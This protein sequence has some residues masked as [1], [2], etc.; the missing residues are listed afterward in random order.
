L[1]LNKETKTEPLTNKEKKQK[2]DEY[3]AFIANHLRQQGYTIAE[4]GKD[5]GVKDHGIDIIAKMNKNI[6]F[7]QCKNWSAKS[8]YKIRDKELKISRQDARDYMMKHPLYT[9]SEYKMKLLYI[10]SEDIFHQS[11]LHYAREHSDIV[12][13][14]VMPM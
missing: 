2:G 3:E 4:H 8:S 5:N 1:E 9:L 6:Y 7:I 12:E 11:A 14:K 13:C 10:V